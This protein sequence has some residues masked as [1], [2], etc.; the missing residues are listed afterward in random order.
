LELKLYSRCV[1][2]ELSRQKVDMGS[3]LTLYTPALDWILQLA[4]HPGTEQ[5]LMDVLTIC[6]NLNMKRLNLSIIY[7][8]TSYLKTGYL[9]WTGAQFDHGCFQGRLHC[10]QS[11][12]LCGIDNSL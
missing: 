6:K 1:R 7:L 5:Q 12:P 4:A 8:F 2:A 3:Y 10:C 9:Q 11:H